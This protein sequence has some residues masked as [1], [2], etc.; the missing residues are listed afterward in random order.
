MR[1]NE[2]AGSSITKIEVTVK[3]IW[4]YKDLGVMYKRN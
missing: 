1:R 4:F 2:I 3:K